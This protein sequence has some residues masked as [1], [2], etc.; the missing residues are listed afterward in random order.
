MVRQLLTTAFLF[1]SVLAAEAQQTLNIH[2]TTRGIVSFA[3]SSEPKVTFAESEVLRV[4]SE[5]M[6]VEFPYAEVV[7]LDFSDQT[8]GVE[9]ITVRE[10]TDGIYIYDLAGKL[11]RH[12]PINGGAATI[13]LSGLRPGTY[14]VKDGRRS[15]KV[16]KP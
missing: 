12:T 11:L 6:T 4:T 10:H 2:T 8:T 14:V 3:F 15:Y 9:T 16:H 1:C 5:T 13:D 7:K